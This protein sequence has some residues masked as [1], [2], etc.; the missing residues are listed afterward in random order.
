[1]TEDGAGATLLE[2]GPESLDALAW[3]Y[4]SGDSAAL[5]SLHAHLSGEVGWLLYRARRHLPAT[6]S[7]EPNDLQQ[8]VWLALAE[9]VAAWDRERDGPFR[10][11]ALRTLRRQVRRCLRRNGRRGW[12]LRAG[13]PGTG[14]ETLAVADTAEEADPSRWGDALLARE[15]AAALPAEERRVLVQHAVAE[16]PVV[17][18]AGEMGVSRRTVDRLL[19]RARLR[20]RAAAGAPPP[21]STLEARVFA[22]VRAGSDRRSGRAP[23]AA[24]LMARTGLGRRRLKT[25]LGKLGQLGY[26]RRRRLRWHLAQLTWD[27]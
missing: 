15:L 13:V 17:A 12:L 21:A 7:V 19:A 16:R 3:A 5:L 10:P 18:L 8:E 14:L 27:E 2:D 20:G 23:A 11:L 6:P 1:M 9:C 4:Q 24:W 26:L 25:T 22:A